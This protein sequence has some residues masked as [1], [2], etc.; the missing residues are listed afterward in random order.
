MLIRSVILLSLCSW[1]SLGAQATST[2][3]SRERDVITREELVASAQKN[4]DLFKAVRSLRSHF[5][6]PP[7]GTRSMTGLPPARVQLYVDGI[8]QS[9][10]AMLE[11]IQTMDAEEVRY[12]DPG[13]AQDLYGIT[14]NGGAILVKRYKGPRPNPTPP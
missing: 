8:R 1:Q 2:P 9:E 11:T 14:H 5:L 7:P 4:Q 3:Q 10:V 12:L 6:R 13:K